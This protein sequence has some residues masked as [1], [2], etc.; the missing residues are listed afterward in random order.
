MNFELQCHSRSSSDPPRSLSTSEQYRYSLISL[1]HHPLIFCCHHCSRY[2]LY[3]ADCVETAAKLISWLPCLPHCILVDRA[4]LLTM[5]LR[6]CKLTIINTIRCFIK[7]LA[8]VGGET[9]SGGPC[10]LNTHR[11][12]VDG[13][14]RQ[15][16]IDDI[17]F[18]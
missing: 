15:L 11:H 12:R 8:A 16:L 18:H 17:V 9:L 6:T 10:L 13:C 3:P 2:P 4:L 1:N 5:F 7:R 14:I